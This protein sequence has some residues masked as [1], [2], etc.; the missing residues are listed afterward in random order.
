MQ[1][2]ES[3]PCEQLVMKLCDIKQIYTQRGGDYVMLWDGVG[4]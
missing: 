1:Y 4:W 2:Q 3:I